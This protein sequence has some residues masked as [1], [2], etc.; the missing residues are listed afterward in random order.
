MNYGNIKKDTGKR[1]YYYSCSL[2]RKSKSELCKNKNLKAEDVE[3][4]AKTHSE[5]SDNNEPSYTYRYRLAGPTCLAG[6][7]IGDY[8]FEEPL[9]EGDIVL[10]GDMAIYT[11]C[12]NNTFNGMMLPDIWRRCE[13]EKIIRLTKFGYEDFKMRLGKSQN[14]HI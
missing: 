4:V 2:K 8:D 13:D 12:K 6:D 3:N 7:V 11:T 10:F 9:R 1:Q 5:V 14:L